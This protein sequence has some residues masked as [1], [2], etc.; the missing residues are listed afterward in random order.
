MWKH[1]LLF[2]N[3]Q[4]DIDLP[5]VILNLEPISDGF[6]INFLRGWGLLIFPTQN[7]QVVIYMFYSILAII[8]FIK[9]STCVMFGVVSAL[10]IVKSNS[11]NNRGLRIHQ[12]NVICCPNYGWP[13]SLG[14]LAWNFLPSIPVQ[15]TLTVST[16]HYQP[17][18]DRM[19]S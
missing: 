8:F 7:T 11:K 2:L 9:L 5:S 1:V 6:V 19:L 16:K 4:I 14:D 15:I 13:R 17:L 10:C 3:L 12:V 18:T